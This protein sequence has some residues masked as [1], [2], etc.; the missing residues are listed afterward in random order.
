M[1]SRVID[2]IEK[3]IDN[4][5]HI[6]DIV[7][8]DALRFEGAVSDNDVL[9]IIAYS[10]QEGFPQI[11]RTKVDLYDK[12]SEGVHAYEVTLFNGDYVGLPVW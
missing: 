5:F 1:S 9:R 7:K 11:I 10:E 6:D 2:D 12:M 8:I 4:L 3:Y